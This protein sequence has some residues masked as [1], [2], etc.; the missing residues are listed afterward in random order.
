MRFLLYNVAYGTGAPRSF[1]HKALVLHRYVR[2]AGHHIDRVH[3]FICQAK[4]DI[5]GL[6]EM[7]SG[8]FRAGGR[9]HAAE[10]ARLLSHDYTFCSKYRRGSIG[11]ILPILRHQGNALFADQPLDCCEHHFL[12]VGFKRLVLDARIRG[13]RFLLVHLAL[14]RHTRELQL[15]Y[16]TRLLEHVTEPVVLA[17]DFNVFQGRRELHH[18]MD[19][20]GL[21]TANVEATPTYPSWR[22]RRELDFILCSRSVRVTDFRVL[23][24]VRLSDHLPL[25][26]DFDVAENV[27]GE[28]AA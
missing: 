15:Y 21:V 5:V 28:H 23:G 19:L 16:L 3:E 4:P 18:L 27:G 14:N 22:P 11:R 2:A 12:P 26:M 20:T 6:V 1:A 7:D 10:I 24:S 25:V 9:N 13:V 17:G 8:S